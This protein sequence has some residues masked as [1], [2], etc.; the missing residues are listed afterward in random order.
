MRSPNKCVAMRQNHKM[1]DGMGW[2]GM[3][4]QA[5]GIPGHDNATFVA[6]ARTC[7]GETGN[8]SD[9]QRDMAMPSTTSSA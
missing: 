1:M 5:V 2:D 9:R 6:H 3:G 7:H 4:R 8:D